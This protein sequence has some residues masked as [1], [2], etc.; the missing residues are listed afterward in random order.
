[1]SSRATERIGLP[2]AEGARRVG[3]EVRRSA[4]RR[5]E[6]HWRR[7]LAH[8]RRPDAEAAGGVGRHVDHS[9][10]ATGREPCEDPADVGPAIRARPRPASVAEPDVQA[11][12]AGC[13][14]RAH[15]RQR[16]ARRAAALDRAD[17]RL[18]A[19][20]LADQ[21]SVSSWTS[22]GTTSCRERAGGEGGLRR[23]SGRRDRPQRCTGSRSA[24]ESAEH[25]A[26]TAAAS[27]PAKTQARPRRATVTTGIRSWSSGW[28]TSPG[29]RC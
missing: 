10:T 24:P 23:G 2:V 11:L 18:R 4:G 29:S 21:V 7:C 1:M 17:G 5:A 13:L 27:G 9:R 12:D 22:A 14:L 26:T 15:C 3:P 19:P 28:S 8:D 6:R 25:P 16:Q 20:A